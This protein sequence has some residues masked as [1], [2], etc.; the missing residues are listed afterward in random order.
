L[1]ADLSA[2]S[3]FLFGESSSLPTA[4]RLASYHSKR[5]R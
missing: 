3:S 1:I 4:S 5:K 2:S